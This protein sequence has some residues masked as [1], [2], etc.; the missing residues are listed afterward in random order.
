M[1]S[2]TDSGYI[3][4]VIPDF[5]DVTTYIGL[6]H[7]VINF[8]ASPLTGNTMRD[9]HI[10]IPVTL[11]GLCILIWSI[12]MLKKDKQT[13]ILLSISPFLSLA[14]FAFGSGLLTALGRWEVYGASQA[15][16]D[17]LVSFGT[18]FWIAVFVLASLAIAKRG[19]IPQKRVLAVLGLLLVL[20]ISNIPGNVQK[21]IEY[22]NTVKEAAEA[23][24]D[25]YPDVTPAE[26]S[27]LH[28]P[29]QRAEVV[30]YLRT[31][32]THKV[33]VFARNREKQQ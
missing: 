10:T 2:G 12:R 11:I 18:F 29:E 3:N 22:S 5:L 27:I 33:S 32:W 20:K 1:F 13:S 31:L 21:K 23:L 24:S 7:F 9:V 25:N 16:V 8:M 26:Y 17:R 28:G 14:V 15:F 6:T 30:E 4:E 19:R